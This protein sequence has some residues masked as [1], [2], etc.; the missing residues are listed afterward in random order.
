VNEISEA[1][2]PD[3]IQ[4]SVTYRLVLNWIRFH[5]RENNVHPAEVQFKITA[6]S[7]GSSNLEDVFISAVHGVE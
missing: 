2:N 5:L 7:P 3:R 4:D 6:A 1:E